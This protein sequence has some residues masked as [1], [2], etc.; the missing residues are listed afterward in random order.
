MDKPR[1]SVIIPTLNE[2]KFLPKLL[3]SLTEQ[4]VG[5]FDVVVVD[6]KSTD[7]TLV[8]A[9]GFKNKIAD[10]TVVASDKP[11]VSRQRN[12]GAS[13]GKADWLVFVDADS[14]LLPN[15]FERISVYIDRKH[16]RFFT[17]WSKADSEDPTEAIIGFLGNIFVEGSVLIDRPWAPGP[18]TVV[19]RDVF[20]MVGGYD[21]NATFAEDHDL[22][23]MIFERGIAFEIF[24]EILYIYS[25]RRWRKEGNFKVFERNMKSTLMVI[26]T[27]RGPKH[28]PGFVPGG[29]IYAEKKKKKKI[30][31]LP[32]EFDRSLRRFIQEFVA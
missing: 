2:E 6:G 25:Y 5:N 1:F 31:L 26:R 7:D 12:L 4:T 3:Q 17:T 19:R 28:M 27:K 14:V 21:E 8:V 32:K 23:M 11:G 13:I 29:A 24:R 18:L 16:S 10:L 15:F 30:R 20:D 22:S 9:H